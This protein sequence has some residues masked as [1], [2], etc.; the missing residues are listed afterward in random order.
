[1][2]E[3]QNTLGLYTGQTPKP[4]IP[5]HLQ[6]VS[7]EDSWCCSECEARDTFTP[8]SGPREIHTHT[9]LWFQLFYTEIHM[10]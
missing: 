5:P 3:R 7:S 8:Q 10:K 4:Q 9:A 1:M 2:L 6:P